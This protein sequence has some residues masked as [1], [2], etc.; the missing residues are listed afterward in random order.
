MSK[1]ETMVQ[2]VIEVAQDDRHG[3]SQYNRWGSL[4]TWSD[5]DCSSLVISAAKYAGFNTGGATYTGNMYWAFRGAGFSDITSTV[6]LRTGAG[7][8]RGDILLNSNYHTEI[9]IGNGK[10]A[11]ARIDENGDIVGRRTGDQTGR[12]IRIDWY[13]NYPWTSVLRYTGKD[14][15]RATPKGGYAG[16]RLIKQERGTA[17][18]GADTNIRSDASINAAVV[19]TYGKGESVNYDSVYESDGYRWISWV[20]GSGARRYAAYRSLNG[21]SWV[22]FGAVKGTAKSSDKKLVKYE[23]WKATF[24]A[25]TNIRANPNLK[26]TVVGMYKKGESVYY[27]SV[28]EG[29]GYRWISWI[30]GSGH[31]RYAAY[32]KLDGEPWVK[33]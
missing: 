3:Y 4:G 14:S 5:Y 18:F 31:R 13:Y 9:Y 27:D 10:T 21:E 20:G 6:N 15:T 17:T 28:Y 33:F 24:K 19:G 1:V 12:E 25:D 16:K 29:D 11:G 2:Y 22:S 7:L 30:G 23:N 32:R 8:R 26:S